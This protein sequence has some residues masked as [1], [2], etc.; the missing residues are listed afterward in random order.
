[1][2][3]EEESKKKKICSCNI[4]KLLFRNDVVYDVQKKWVHSDFFLLVFFEKQYDIIDN[5][6]YFIK[7][8]YS[9]E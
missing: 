3:V 7:R 2:A 6:A 5:I 8:L 1:M 9:R 4:K